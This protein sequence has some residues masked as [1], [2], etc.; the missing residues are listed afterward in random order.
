MPN[1]DAN[2]LVLLCSLSLEFFWQSVLARNVELR[3]HAWFGVST[4]Q[5]ADKA[6]SKPSGLA[7]L[8][9]FDATDD[10]LISS[11]LASG[12]GDT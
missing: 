10:G 1:L 5:L 2:E 4:L 7:T 12:G 3:L 6:C 9:A 11:Q 8:F